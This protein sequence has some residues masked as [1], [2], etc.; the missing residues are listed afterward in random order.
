[1]ELGQAR[2]VPGVHVVERRAVQAHS[3]AANDFGKWVAHRRVDHA[4]SEVDGQ[5]D[6]LYVS[7]EWMD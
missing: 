3:Q 7:E 2:H 6:S 1:M 4:E 5:R